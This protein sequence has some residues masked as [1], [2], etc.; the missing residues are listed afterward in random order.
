ME[1]NDGRNDGTMERRNFKRNDAVLCLN[2]LLKDITKVK[3]IEKREACQLQTKITQ[4]KEKSKI[5]DQKLLVSCNIPYGYCIYLFCF[6]F[7]FYYTFFGI[8]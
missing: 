1:R 5:T 3:K 6:S 2:K 4:Y 8:Y 7:F